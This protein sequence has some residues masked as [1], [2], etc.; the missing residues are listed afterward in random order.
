MAAMTVSSLPA[1]LLRS[2][3]VELWLETRLPDAAAREAI[4]RER[5]HQLPPP[6]C[7]ADLSLLASGSRGPAGADL[8]AIVEDG[9]LSLAHDRALAKPLRARR[10]IS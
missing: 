6:I 8:R 7:T 4:L 2:G 5:L 10:P 9:N 1:A 3:G